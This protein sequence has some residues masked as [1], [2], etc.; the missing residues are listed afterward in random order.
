MWE[1]FGDDRVRTFDLGVVHLAG[2][3][4]RHT[5]A[6]LWEGWTYL[7]YGAVALLIVIFV[8]RMIRIKKSLEEQKNQPPRF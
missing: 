5:R 8:R 2:T 4:A 7:Q 1:T 3:G 6:T